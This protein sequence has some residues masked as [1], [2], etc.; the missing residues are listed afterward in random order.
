MDSIRQRLNSA[1]TD[2]LT[3]VMHGTSA[4]ESFYEAWDGLM[5]DI[6]HDAATMDEELSS[7]VRTTA[8][9]VAI[10]AEASHDLYVDCDAL[11]TG[12]VGEIEDI[13]SGLSIASVV[14]NPPPSPY[15]HCTKQPLEAQDSVAENIWAYSPES[16]LSSNMLAS[17][18]SDSSLV[19]VTPYTKLSPVTDS[20]T[21]SWEEVDSSGLSLNAAMRT[22][23]TPSLSSSVSSDDSDDDETPM[24]HKASRKRTASSWYDDVDEYSRVTYSDRP[25]KRV[26][27]HIGSCDNAVY[28]ASKR[29]PSTGYSADI[30]DTSVSAVLSSSSN[31]SGETPNCRPSFPPPFTST[32]HPQPTSL[33]KKRRHS[34]MD[35]HEAPHGETSQQL[36]L[37]PRS[38]AVSDPC[39]FVTAK[40]PT[41]SFENWS[42]D[43]PEP[44]STSGLDLSVPLDIEVFTG[45]DEVW[46]G[47]TN[48]FPLG[49]AT[50]GQMP[51]AWQSVERFVNAYSSA[52]SDTPRRATAESPLRRDHCSPDPIP[53]VPAF[54]VQKATSSA[55]SFLLDSQTEPFNHLPVL[56]DLATNHTSSGAHWYQNCPPSSGS[57]PPLYLECP[58][59]VPPL[60]LG[61]FLDQT[62]A[63]AASNPCP[64]YDQSMETTLYTPSLFVG[65]EKSISESVKTLTSTTP[66]ASR[67]T[68]DEAHIL[69]QSKSKLEE[70][71]AAKEMVRRLEVEVGITLL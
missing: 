44:V 62:S 17:I 6:E 30:M 10:L 35:D 50:S 57:P 45:W 14:P 5:R 9:R 68:L 66:S 4:L 53:D 55:A 7:L 65:L 54:I 36:P 69:P 19:D 18:H 43:I 22:T 41:E 47:L 37:Q 31:P 29:S 48:E 51:Q 60:D 32:D 38:Y 16:G 70:L 71:E 39:S 63:A 27:T 33:R 52:P 20:W 61:Y 67:C 24:A 13:L 40:I 28:P 64:P 58:S 2:F 15:D 49:N 3:A 21:P 11:T 46:E 56:S 34:D 59:Q 12:M 26:K 1:E 42:F 25:L 8:T 23:R